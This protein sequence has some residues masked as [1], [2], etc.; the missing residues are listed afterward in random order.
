MMKK[1][2]PATYYSNIF[3]LTSADHINAL[4]LKRREKSEMI[5][6]NK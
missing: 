6:H 1:E 2:E 3:D 5:L 4:D